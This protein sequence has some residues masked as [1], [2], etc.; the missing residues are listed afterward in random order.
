MERKIMVLLICL[1]VSGMCGCSR[2]NQ[3]ENEDDAQKW[4]VNSENSEAV[5]HIPAESSGDSSEKDE[6]KVISFEPDSP[7]NYRGK[8]LQLSYSEESVKVRYRDAEYEIE[9]YADGIE[10]GY[11]MEMDDTGFYTI[12]QV[13]SANDWVTS[14]ILK[15]DG[16]RFTE[17][18]AQNGG[19]GDKSSISGNQITFDTRVD[20]FGTYGV[21]I[22]MRLENDQLTNVD[23]FIKFVNEPDPE[24]YDSFDSPE[25]KAIYNKEGYRVLT[26]KRTLM[27]MSD[28]GNIEIGKGQQ[29]IPD[30]YNEKE[31]KFYFRYQ[32]KQYYFTYEEDQDGYT[33]TIDGVN[34]EDMFV[35]LPYA[36]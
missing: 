23:D 20:V 14:Y 28:D 36:G 12:I 19:V 7:V 29:I 16:N 1:S 25:S 21:K 6:V 32:D 34:Q 15:Y 13:C 5:E 8:E 3:T 18:A 4:V 10:T 26:L 33:F 2:Q 17:I 27:A 9:D 35:Y 11:I 22:P 31:K 24:I 30:G